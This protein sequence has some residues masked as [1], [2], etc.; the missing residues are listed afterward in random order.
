M[1]PFMALYGAVSGMAWYSAEIAVSVVSLDCLAHRQS[2]W[3][4][5]NRVVTE[6]QAR[7]SMVNKACY[8]LLCIR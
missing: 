5:G 6:N 1:V 3:L 4:F 7:L 8:R 2:D